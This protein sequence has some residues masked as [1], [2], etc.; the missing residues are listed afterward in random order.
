MN[1]NVGRLFI[2]LLQ[3]NSEAVRKNEEYMIKYCSHTSEKGNYSDWEKAEEHSKRK[4]D[5]RS[6]AKG[7]SQ[8]RTGRTVL[9]RQKHQLA[10]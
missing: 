4:E 1:L 6:S 10:W 9:T 5:N 8:P 2:Y 3:E 7:Q